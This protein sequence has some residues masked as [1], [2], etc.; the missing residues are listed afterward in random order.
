MLKWFSPGSA[1]ASG[2]RSRPQACWIRR[3][4]RRYSPLSS[5]PTTATKRPRAGAGNRA[6]LASCTCCGVRRSASCRLGVC[7]SGARSYRPDRPM[8]RFTTSGGSSGSN[9]F[10][11][12]ASIMAASWPPA[13]W[14]MTL[15]RRGS[16]FSVRACR[17]LQPTARATCSVIC[18][19]LACGASV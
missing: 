3:F 19:M 4:W 1:A 10:Q 14:P 8:A 12:Q 15:M 11:A 16:A 13:E 9:T 5:P 6:G 7:I 18:G 17:Q 2:T